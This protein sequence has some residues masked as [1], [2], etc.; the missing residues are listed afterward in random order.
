M[1]ACVP[2]AEME[3]GDGGEA[4]GLQAGAQT[5]WAYRYDVSRAK[6][7]LGLDPRYRMEDGLYQTIE[8]YRRREGLP[9]APRPPAS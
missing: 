5:N 6:A 4:A 8:A 3:L 2:D 7:I 1:Q 9:L